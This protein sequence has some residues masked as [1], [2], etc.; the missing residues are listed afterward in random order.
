L[1]SSSG[2]RPEPTSNPERLAYLLA[3]LL[4]YSIIVRYGRKRASADGDDPPSA[5]HPANAAN[6]ASLF[7]DP[8][9]QLFFYDLHQSRSNQ[10]AFSLMGGLLRTPLRAH[11]AVQTRMPG[12]KGSEKRVKLF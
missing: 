1:F 4:A 6:Q 3:Y 10:S 2:F 11:A 5:E 8:E 12:E 9:N 7:D